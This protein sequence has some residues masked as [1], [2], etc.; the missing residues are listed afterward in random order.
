[1]NS[2][3]LRILFLA[4][5]SLGSAAP[6]HARG[7]GGCVEQGTP[8]LTPIGPVAI[9]RLRA[10][11]TVLGVTGNSAGPVTVRSVMEVQPE[12]YIELSVN[13]RVLRLTSEHPVETSP[14]IFRMASLLRKGDTVILRESGSIVPALLSSVTP[15]RGTRPAYNLLVSPAGTYIA[16][17]IVVHNKGCFLPDTPVRNADGTDVPISA[18]RPGDR[19]LAFTSDGTVVTA[20]VRQVLV[21]DAEEYRIV[22]TNSMVLKVTPEHP[23]YVGDGTFKTLEALRPGNSI[24]AYDG[25]GMTPQRIESIESVRVPT[26]VYNLMTDAPH[27]FFANGIAVHNKGGGGCFP[28]GTT[29]LTPKGE[30]PIERILPDDDVTTVD[31]NGTGEHRRPGRNCLW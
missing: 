2:F 19:L 1:M 18:V 12:E 13:G 6:A 15:V 28:A 26:R 27:T 29:V 9:E 23:F 22:R 16:N 31:D 5:L 4:V 25:S 24:R 30:V 11:D 10:G 20:T 8:V 14:G 3:I 7:G 21:H 17:S